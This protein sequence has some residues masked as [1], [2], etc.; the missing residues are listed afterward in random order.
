MNARSPDEAGL[1]MTARVQGLPYHLPPSG[2]QRTRMCPNRCGRKGSASGREVVTALRRSGESAATSKVRDR[3][4]LSYERRLTLAR[5]PRPFG[6]E[7]ERMPSHHCLG[8]LASLPRQS[9]RRGPYSLRGAYASACTHSDR[10]ASTPP[11]GPFSVD[12]NA[13]QTR[14][15]GSLDGRIFRGKPV[16][17][18]QP[19]TCDGTSQR[20][21]YFLGCSLTCMPVRRDC[22]SQTPSASERLGC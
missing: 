8:E 4:T 15:G 11:G 3:R 10:R 22:D 21:R 16:V 7:P 6:T 12:G 17:R 13:R 9:V 20:L 14:A 19:E 2:R 18:R 5:R 1:R